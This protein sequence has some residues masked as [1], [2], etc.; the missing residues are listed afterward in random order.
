V[1]RGL[2]SSTLACATLAS[3]KKADQLC[4]ECGS[5]YEPEYS[6]PLDFPILDRLECP[7]VEDGQEE[8]YVSETL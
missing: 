8:G 3:L 1:E 6:D 4:Y 5:R 7:S 2:L